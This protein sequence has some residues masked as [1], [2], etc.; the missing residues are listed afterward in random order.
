MESKKTSTVGIGL[1]FG[2]AIGAGLG[3][4][5]DN[6]PIGAGIGAAFGII[7]G[8]IIDSYKNKTV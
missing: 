5:F 4:I 2:V 6:M 3:L 1:V 7:I 8:A